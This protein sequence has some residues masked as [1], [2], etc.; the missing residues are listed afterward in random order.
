MLAL[1]VDLLM[2]GL[3]DPATLLQITLFV[4]S[5]FLTFQTQ[6]GIA[7]SR[8]HFTLDLRA[9]NLLAIAHHLSFFRAHLHPAFGVFTKSLSLVRR[10]CHPPIAKIGPVMLLR[11]SHS[12]H[13]S[14]V[15]LRLVSAVRLSQR[16]PRGENHNRE[17]CG[18]A[19]NVCVSSSHRLL[20]SEAI[21]SSRS[22]TT[23]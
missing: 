10:Q 22:A 19:Y 23:S 14:T 4:L 18:R 8:I 7:Q 21:N 5:A 12:R 13:I 15:R 1:R 17:H 11:R 20:S 2:Q 16:R 9:I 3:F 6:T